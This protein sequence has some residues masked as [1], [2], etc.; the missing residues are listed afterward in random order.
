MSV[1]RTGALPDSQKY[2]IITVDS[3]EERQLKGQVYHECLAQGLPFGCIS[4]MAFVLEG[5][6][7]KLRYPMKSVDQR[8]FN[9]KSSGFK[10]Q[11]RIPE[12]VNQ[13]VQAKGKLG[14]FRLHVK[15]RFYATWQ[16]DITNLRD[17]STFSFL[18]FLEL[19]EYFNRTFGGGSE[20]NQYGLGK[21]MCE[22]VVRN[23]EDYIL[24]GDISHP[25]VEH[26]KHFKNEFDIKE[27]IEYMLNP[28]PQGEQTQTVIVPRSMTI[29]TGNYGP[30]TF[31]VRVLFRRNATWQGTICWKE[32]HCQVSFRSFLELILLIQNAVIGN[33]DWKEDLNTVMAAE[34]A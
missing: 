26:R 23:Y 34:M 16:G 31:V 17:G 4:E 3:F 21:K 12:A 13:D 25:S 5:M 11:A 33:E 29:V 24:S 19:L 32:A 1:G 14:E 7:D 27:A 30:A 2:Y 9:K 18:S 20:D 28:L 10:S 6:F 15:Y 22:V 8:N